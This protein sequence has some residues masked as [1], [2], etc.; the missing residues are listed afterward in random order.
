ML[1]PLLGASSNDNFGNVFCRRQHKSRRYHLIRTGRFADRRAVSGVDAL[2]SLELDPY[3][4][5]RVPMMRTGDSRYLSS[6]RRGDRTSCARP[7]DNLSLRSAMAAA[8]RSSGRTTSSPPRTDRRPTTSGNVNADCTGPRDRKV[9]SF[10]GPG[11]EQS[12]VA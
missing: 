5:V 7:R 4:A 6:I 1:P 2:V 3:H 11:V 12:T 10:S 9:S 8:D